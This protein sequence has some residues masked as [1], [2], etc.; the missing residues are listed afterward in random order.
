MIVTH[1]VKTDNLFPLKLSK[2]LPVLT[3][4]TLIIQEICVST[5]IQEKSPMLLPIKIFSSSLYKH[6]LSFFDDLVCHLVE[7]AS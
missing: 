6:K 4:L 5:K 3:L 1:S 2:N 7:I